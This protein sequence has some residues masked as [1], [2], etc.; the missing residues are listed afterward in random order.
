MAAS[1]SDRDAMDECLA[2]THAV[3]VAT[4]RPHKCGDPVLSD[5]CRALEVAGC[6]IAKIV[7]PP[8]C[9]QEC[10]M[11]ARAV[12]KNKS[13]GTILVV[14]NDVHN[15][16]AA[17][18]TIVRLSHAVGTAYGATRLDMAILLNFATWG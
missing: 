11:L 4:A 10:A 6:T 14:G 18:D 3:V 8:I 13:L 17:Y 7:I 9:E 1:S 5:L 16:K 2:F 15:I 12:S